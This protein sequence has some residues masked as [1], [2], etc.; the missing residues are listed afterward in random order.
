MHWTDQCC[1]F[2]ANGALKIANAPAAASVSAVAAKNVTKTQLLRLSSL[3]RS[4]KSRKRRVKRR[5]A[6]AAIQEEADITHPVT[7]ATPIPNKI[8]GPA[9]V[10]KS[11][12]LK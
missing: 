5:V 9:V 3:K 8:M 10:L 2:E 12:Q 4:L 11:L 7:A 6:N 1:A